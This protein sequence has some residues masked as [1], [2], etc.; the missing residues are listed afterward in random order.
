[1]ARL[2]AFLALFWAAPAFAQ[3][4]APKDCSGTV[5]TASAAI[6][7]STPPALYVLLA[8]PSATATLAVNPN[9]A[10]VVGG[11]GSITIN[12]SGVANDVLLLSVAQGVPPWATINIIASAATTPYTCKYQ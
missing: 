12:T 2:I 1:M 5:G 4:G 10:A 3:V 9:G 7:F 6:T 8:N 11:S